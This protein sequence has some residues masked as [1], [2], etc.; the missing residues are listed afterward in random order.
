VPTNTAVEAGFRIEM[1]IT[2]VSGVVYPQ[3]LKLRAPPQSADW[4]LA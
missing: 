1:K 2:P 4:R 3:T